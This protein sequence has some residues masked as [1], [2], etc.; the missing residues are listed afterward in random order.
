MTCREDMSQVMNELSSKFEGKAFLLFPKCDSSHWSLYALFNVYGVEN[1]E[2]RS[3]LY[4]DSYNKEPNQDFIKKL[5]GWLV[6]KSIKGNDQR[7]N[8]NNTEQP[9]GH[10]NSESRQYVPLKK[11]KCNF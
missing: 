11:I 2:N 10:T 8:E 7:T 1:Y 6:S 9:E 3:I 5:S 4:L